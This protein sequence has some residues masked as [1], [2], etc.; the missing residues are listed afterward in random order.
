MHVRGLVSLVVVLSWRLVV[1]AVSSRHSHA[2]VA[3][4]AASRRTWGSLVVQRRGKAAPVTP[5]FTA[6][7][8]EQVAPVAHAGRRRAAGART[9]GGGQGRNLDHERLVRLLSRWF[10]GLI[11]GVGAIPL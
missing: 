3:Q 5:A 10:L 8:R 9:Q 2:H 1:E 11:G 4:I 6:A 7:F